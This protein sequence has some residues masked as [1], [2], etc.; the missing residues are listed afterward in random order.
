MYAKGSCLLLGS[1]VQFIQAIPATMPGGFV[2]EEASEEQSW[3]P[4][5]RELSLLLFP[6]GGLPVA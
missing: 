2:E 3:L 1:S 6:F 5:V 4:V